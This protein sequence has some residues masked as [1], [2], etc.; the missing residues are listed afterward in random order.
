MLSIDGIGIRPGSHVPRL[1][2][3]LWQDDEGTVHDVQRGEGGRRRIRPWTAQRVRHSALSVDST[4]KRAA[5]ELWDPNSSREDPILEQRRV[6][7]HA[8]RSDPDAIIWRC[9]RTLPDDQ[10]GVKILGTPFSSP[11]FVSPRLLELI[12]SHQRLVDKIPLYLICT[13]RGCFYYSARLR[14]PTTSWSSASTFSCCVLVGK[15]GGG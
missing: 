6:P 11:Q 3:S 1:L 4:G 7:P 14:A 13:L 2:F 5:H 9:D 15:A 12:A 10:R 8:W